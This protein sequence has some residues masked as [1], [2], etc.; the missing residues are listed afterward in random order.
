M[1]TYI[2]KGSDSEIVENIVISI[3]CSS[4]GTSVCCAV[5]VLFWYRING[6]FV[7]VP[8]TTIFFENIEIFDKGRVSYRK[9]PIAC[10]EIDF[11]S[12]GMIWRLSFFFSLLIYQ[13]RDIL[14]YIVARRERLPALSCGLPLKPSKKYIFF[15]V[16]R[17]SRFFFFTVS[18]TPS[19]KNISNCSHGRRPL[20]IAS[21]SVSTAQRRGGSGSRTCNLATFRSRDATHSLFG[22]LKPLCGRD[23][24]SRRF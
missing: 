4:L 13:N 1:G 19:A 15:P 2:R 20:H 6:N 3:I 24:E 12:F 16:E 9:V 21:G 22:E 23:A 10:I 7:K 17:R 18:H 5:H 11:D 8:I 14:L